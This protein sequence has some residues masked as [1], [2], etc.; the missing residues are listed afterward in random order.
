MGDVEPAPTA[1]H[2]VPFQRAMFSTGTPPAFCTF[3]PA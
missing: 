1:D 3:P 2:A